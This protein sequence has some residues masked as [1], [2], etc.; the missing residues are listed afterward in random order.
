[1]TE[2]P[3]QA[4]QRFAE[5]TLEL[6]Y[7]HY[8]QQKA[9]SVSVSTWHR[10]SEEE[11]GLVLLSTNSTGTRQKGTAKSGSLLTAQRLSRIG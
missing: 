2:S 3:P 6:I 11:D 8:T 9:E 5:L 1:M 10:D 7:R 4:Q